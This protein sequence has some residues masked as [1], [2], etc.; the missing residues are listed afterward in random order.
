MFEKLSSEG[1]DTIEPYTQ[2]VAEVSPGEEFGVETGIFHP[3]PMTRLEL[4]YANRDDNSQTFSIAREI[5]QGVRTQH[6]VQ[7]VGAVPEDQPPGVYFCQQVLVTTKE[8]IKY[9]AAYVP[10]DTLGIRIL[11]HMGPPRTNG[12]RV[13]KPGN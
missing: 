13:F 6:G 1:E 12:W 3:A 9:E 11:E 5:G 2:I 8:G 10:N 7:V 4:V